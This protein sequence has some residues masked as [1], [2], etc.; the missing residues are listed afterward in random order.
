MATSVR[1]GEVRHSLDILD[2][3]VLTKQAHTQYVPICT[4][5]V[6]AYTKDE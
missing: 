5:F 4:R 2:M 6:L 3:G 1:F